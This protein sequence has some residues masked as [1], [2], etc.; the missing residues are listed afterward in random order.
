MLSFYLSMVET[1]EDSEKVTYIYENYLPFMKY[2]ASLILTNYQDIEDVVHDAMTKIIEN[3]NFI[4]FSNMKMVKCLCG[5]IV[6]HMAIDLIKLH[7][8]HNCS[9]EVEA[10]GYLPEED[11]DQVIVDEDSYEIILKTIRSMSDTYR[12]VFILR[13][14]NGLKEREIAKLLDIKIG[15][16]GAKLSRGRKILK[17]AIRKEKL[18][19]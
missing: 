14:V 17:E 15:T 2:C 4:D 18:H 3:I 16:V 12:D 9:M 13:Y 8:N 19:E 10:V 7:E 11:F 5:I 6:K 1:E